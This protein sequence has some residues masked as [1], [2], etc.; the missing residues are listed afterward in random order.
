[1]ITKIDSDTLEITCKSG[2]VIT[3]A[4]QDVLDNIA[5]IQSDLAQAQSNAAE[6]IAELEA[7]I[8]LL[9]S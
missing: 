2:A 7:Y 1:M 9:D 4:R 8:A 3:I 5:A 6:Q